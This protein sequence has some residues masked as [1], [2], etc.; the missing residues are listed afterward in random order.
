M[1]PRPGIECTSVHNG[2][3]GFISPNANNRQL[4]GDLGF[5]SLGFDFP[6]GDYVP[7]DKN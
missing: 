2:G 3:L 5:D 7:Y 4:I 6:Q 1:L